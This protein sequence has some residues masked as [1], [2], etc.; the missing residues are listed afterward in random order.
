[1]LD[2]RPTAAF[3]Q[4]HHCDAINIPAAELNQRLHELPK[5]NQCL[6]LCGDSDSLT[7]ANSTLSSKGYQ[8]QQCFEW[9]S[10][11]ADQLM[12]QGLFCLGASPIRLWNAG[13]LVQRFVQEIAPHYAIQPG[14]GVD[15]ACGAGR[16][17]VYLALHGW[18][19]TGV[20]YLPGAIQ[21]TQQLAQQQ[22]VQVNTLLLDLESVADPFAASALAKQS[23]NLVVVARYLHRP[24][25]ALLPNLLA[26]GGI[27]LYQTFMQGSEQFGSPRNPNYLLRPQELAQTFANLAILLDEID[28]LEDGRPVS[29]FIARRPF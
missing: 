27:L 19:M 21:R 22:Q 9:N 24:L 10:A 3:Y 15:L 18:Q 20:D 26:P 28:Y 1:L 25:L 16:D 14:T 29:A 13:G 5:R 23:F 7:H 17:T 11:Y 6:Q 4:G 8:I 12:R 2:C